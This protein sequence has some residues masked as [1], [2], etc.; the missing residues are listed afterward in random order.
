MIIQAVIGWSILA[1]SLI[2]GSTFLGSDML[3][4][5]LIM[6]LSLGYVLSRSYMGFAG[7]VNRAYKTGSTKLMRALMLMLFATAVLNAGLLFNGLTN[8]NLWINPIN[9]GLMLG[10]LLFGFG[11]SLSVCCASGVLTDLAADLPRAFI[12]LFFFMLGVFLGF[13]IQ[14]TASFVRESW[15]NTPTGKIMDTGTGVYLPDLFGG[16]TVS[17]YLFAIALTG[18]FCLIVVWFSFKYENKRKA[19]LSYNAIPTEEVKSEEYGSLKYSSFFSKEMYHYLF[20]KPWNLKVGVIIITIIVAVMMAVTKEGWG[21]ST[22]YGWWFG[23]LLTVVG[24]SPDAIAEFTHWP[25]KVFTMPFFSHPINVQN[26]AIMLGALI[27]M[28]QSG[29]F[30]MS[31][32]S[33]LNISW[34]SALLFALG[35]LAMGFGTR[36]ANGCNVGALYT[37]IAN[38]SLSGWV[39]AIFMTIGAIFGN[40][41]NGKIAPSCSY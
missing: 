35:G 7:T 11:M 16:Q 20:I 38:L 40:K 10:G 3:F 36:L 27:F 37:P 13:P 39:F 22:P 25:T 24:I 15:F 31:F 12:T 33:S 23:K 8:Y 29:Q 28:L 2:F 6:G 26:F 14:K 9:T 41:F 17:A 21:A 19:E 30:K 4:F 5:R 32:Q 34:K 1:I 18:V